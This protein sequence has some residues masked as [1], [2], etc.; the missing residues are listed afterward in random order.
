MDQCPAKVT[1]WL[2]SEQGCFREPNIGPMTLAFLGGP[3]VLT[4]QPY[5]H[6]LP[7]QLS[8]SQDSVPGLQPQVLL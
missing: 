4:S 7:Y 6:L 3:W 2:G 5:V 8:H 1:Q